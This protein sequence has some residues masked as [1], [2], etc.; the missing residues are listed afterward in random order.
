M[1]GTLTGRRVAILAARGVEQAELVQPRQAVT[2][3]GATTELLSLEP[4]TVQATNHDIEP[5]DQFD[6][7]RVVAEASIDDYDALLLPGG[8]VNPDTLRQNSAA[9]GFVRDFVAA[10]K[11]VGVICHGP[12]TLV[13]ADVVRG[14]TLTSWPSMRTDIRNAGCTVRDQ[15]VVTDGN[16]V[17]SRGPDDLP[18]FCS[19]IV[20][21]FAAT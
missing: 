7:D 5:A 9:V 20:A 12:W 11:P 14:R 15:E 19:A 13:E 17:S 10:G 6:V 2:E 4:G 1:A 3:A 18:A 8:A 16:L 21:H